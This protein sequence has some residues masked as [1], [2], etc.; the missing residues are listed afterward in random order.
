MPVLL[1]F[2]LFNMNVSSLAV[3]HT[4]PVMSSNAYADCDHRI[5]AQY[6]MLTS[7]CGSL[8]RALKNT[9]FRKM[10]QRVSELLMI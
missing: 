9:P 1:L 8:S 7:A 6:V 4:S 3:A 10:L 2:P 5:T